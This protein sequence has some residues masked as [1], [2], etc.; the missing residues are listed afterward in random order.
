MIA[1]PQTKRAF[2]CSLQRLHTEHVGVGLKRTYG[3]PHACLKHV[4][5]TLELF[6]SFRLDENTHRHDYRF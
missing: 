3:I 1:D 4:R 5:Q 6:L 2:E